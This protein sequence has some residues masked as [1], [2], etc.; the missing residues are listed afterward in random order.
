MKICEWN[1]CHEEIGDKY[2]Y[3]FGHYQ[4]GKKTDLQAKPKG[5]W[6]EDPTVSVLMQCNSNLGKIAQL[7]ERIAL[8]N[9]ETGGIPRPVTPIFGS[10][11]NMKNAD[12]LDST[13]EEKENK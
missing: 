6:H 3:C 13:Y 11:R 10:E 5:Q 2:T 9:E 1:G 4:T 7:L 12:F 8:V